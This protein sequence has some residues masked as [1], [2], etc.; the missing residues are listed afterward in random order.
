[1]KISF[2]LSIAVAVV[3]VVSVVVLWSSLNAAH[4]F[5]QINTLVRNKEYFGT[6]LSSFDVLNYVGLN[7]VLGVAILL[8]LVNAVLWTAIATLWAFLY[9][10]AS[11]LLGGIEVTLAETD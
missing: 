9:N 11:G 6:A 2:M 10:L 8:A 1:M 7:K 4:V 3:Q 5:T